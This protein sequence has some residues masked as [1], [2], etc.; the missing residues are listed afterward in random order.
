MIPV[1]LLAAEMKLSNL[2]MGLRYHLELVDAVEG[3]F[4][5]VPR[6]EV[7]ELVDSLQR[8]AP[9]LGALSAFLMQPA[10][11]KGDG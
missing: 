2:A 3:A 7:E 1:G 4:A 5:L 6:G 10:G 9:Y 8:I 11:R